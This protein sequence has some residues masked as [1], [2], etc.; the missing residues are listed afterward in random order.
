MITE[1]KKNRTISR[2]RNYANSVSKTINIQPTLDGN[3]RQ[4]NRTREIKCFLAHRV[5][6]PEAPRAVAQRISTEH[7]AHDVRLRL[8]RGDSRVR[9]GRA[10]G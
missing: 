6:R 10:F 2:T 3:A 8:E 7:I 5:S 1:L 4:V 9:G